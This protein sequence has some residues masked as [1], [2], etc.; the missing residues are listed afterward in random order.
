MNTEQHL[1]E[2]HGPLMTLPVLAKMLDRTTTGLR[3]FL[4]QDDDISRQLNRARLK[5]GR[6]VYFRT[7]MVSR[8]IDGEGK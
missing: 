1:V 4:R 5:I 2:K 7:S 6:R 8:V 3:L